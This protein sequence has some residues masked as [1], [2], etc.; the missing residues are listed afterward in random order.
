MIPRLENLALGSLDP[1]DVETLISAFEHL[2]RQDFVD[3][4]RIGYV[5]FCVGA[6]LALVAA[7][8]P[9]I[10]KKIAFVSV[11]GGYYD[12][13]ELGRAVITQ[14]IRYNGQE[15]VWRP[16][17][18]TVEGFIR[19]LANAIKD[20]QDSAILAQIS[21]STQPPNHHQLRNLS[22]I[23][24]RIF[25]LLTT[26]DPA[27]IE[28]LMAQLPPDEIAKLRVLSPSTGINRLHAKVFIIHDPDDPFIPPTEARHLADN[29]PDNVERTYTE[30][31][32]F[33]HVRPIRTL[34]KY[35]LLGEVVKLYQYLYHIMRELG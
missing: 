16:A 20:A 8:D 4:Q 15:K 23:G 21:S 34:N 28:A 22:P 31:R 24:R 11:V 5:G 2:Q 3:P 25:E 29:L 13:F 35:L 14:R 33:R 10:N 9:R 12:V 6:S 30:L 26:D 32:L 19:Y 1:V 7:E 18:Q 27:R 17:H